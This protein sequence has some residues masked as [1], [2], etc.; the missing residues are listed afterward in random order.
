[1]S[2]DKAEPIGLG[3]DMHEGEFAWDMLEDWEQEIITQLVEQEDAAKRNEEMNQS[4]KERFLGKGS[5]ESEPADDV[6]ESP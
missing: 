6:K 3:K 1:M 4:L 2:E 5:S